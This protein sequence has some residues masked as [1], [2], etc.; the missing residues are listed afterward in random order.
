MKNLKAFEATINIHGT[1]RDVTYSP[2][3]EDFEDSRLVIHGVS[4]DD[5]FHI[6]SSLEGG[7][8]KGKDAENPPVAT[9]PAAAPK[10]E[11]KKETTKAKPAKV[12]EA[13]AEEKKPEP[14]PEP[15]PEPEADDDDLDSDIDDASD[16][17]G[18]LD[19]DAM[20]KMDKLRPV[21]EH[22]ISRGFKTA[23]DIIDRASQIYAKVPALAEVHAKGNFEKR[24]ERAALVVLGGET[25]AS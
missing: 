5:A 11:A 7:L 6:L 17:G 25:A 16:E 1:E 10:T 23:K 9:T 24:M 20:A 3:V 18:E 19:I 14:K 12:I 15:E 13:K 22:M 2:K 21:I 8:L 4:I